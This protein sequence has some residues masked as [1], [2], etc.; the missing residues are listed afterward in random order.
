MSQRAQISWVR[1][2]PVLIP[3]GIIATALAVFHLRDFE[4]L[5]T[6]QPW[7]GPMETVSL[8]QGRVLS[9]VVE[10][11]GVF[12]GDVCVPPSELAAYLQSHRA[13]IAPDYVIVFGTADAS[14]G[15]FVTTFTTVRTIFRGIGATVDTRSLPPGTR[16]PRLVRINGWGYPL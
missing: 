12:F 5:E 1:L 10:R 3:A 2:C 4:S 11:E 14:Y 13:R 15:D 6:E 9:I 8:P 16:V 7:D